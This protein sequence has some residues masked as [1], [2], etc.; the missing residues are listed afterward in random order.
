MVAR[1]GAHDI[2]RESIFVDA[3]PEPMESDRRALRWW[4]GEFQAEV[5]I[6]GQESDGGNLI[7]RN[8]SAVRVGKLRV[9]GGDCPRISLVRAIIVEGE[10]PSRRH[11]LWTK[12]CDFQT[13][14]TPRK[15]VSFFF[16]IFCS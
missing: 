2:E 15:H 4:D 12:R 10:F 9:P 5:I 7:G 1:V 6:H 16:H 3:H 14:Y 11:V 8:Y 13:A